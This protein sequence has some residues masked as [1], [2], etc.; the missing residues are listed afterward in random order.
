MKDPIIIPNDHVSFFGWSQQDVL[1]LQDSILDIQ[2]EL[3]DFGNILYN[4][5]LLVL[6]AA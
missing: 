6:G 3:H 1:R 2:E 5:R 4:S